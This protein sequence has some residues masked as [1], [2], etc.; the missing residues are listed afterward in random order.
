M[1]NA[2][3]DGLAADGALNYEL[4]PSTG[5]L[6]DSKQWWPQAE[7]M[8]GFVNAY[9]LSGK[10]HFLEKQ[11]SLGIRKEVYDRSKGRGVGG[12]PLTRI[13]RSCPE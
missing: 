1:A 2:A 11:K 5:H 12:L 7:A 10:V 9:Q 13:I 4:E 6:N 8:V 3:S